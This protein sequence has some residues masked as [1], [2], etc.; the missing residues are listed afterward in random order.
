MK[1]VI[2]ISVIALFIVVGVQ[3]AFAVEPKVSADNI[4]KEEDCDCK[5]VSEIDFNRLDKLNEI[6]DLYNRF[7]TLQEMSYPNE[8]ECSKLLFTIVGIFVIVGLIDT[9]IEF[10]NINEYDD[11]LLLMFLVNIQNKWYK[12]LDSFIELYHFYD[13]WP[14]EH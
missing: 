4:E 14:E 12:R 9:I 1:K 11:P 13:C 10:G 3:P 6:K 8:S 2:V 7:S 5:E